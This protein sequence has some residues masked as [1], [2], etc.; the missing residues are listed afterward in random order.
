M[1]LTREVAQ[2]TGGEAIFTTLLME[3]ASAVI[4]ALYFSTAAAPPGGLPG[5]L[6]GLT[7]LTS[8]GDPLKDL[9]QLAETVG[10]SAGSGEVVFIGS[11]GTASSLNLR[12]DIRDDVVIFGSVAVPSGRLICVDPAAIIHAINPVP[13]ITAD[14]QTTLHMDSMPANISSVGTPPTVAA[15]TASM[16]QTASTS[17]RLVARSRLRPSGAR[18]ALRLSTRSPGA[19][20]CFRRSFPWSSPLADHSAVSATTPSAGGWAFVG[21]GAAGTF[22]SGLD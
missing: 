19:D 4:D 20:R 18:T 15:P 1:T 21:P 7:P 8:L 16:L 3:N 10:G 13:D 17:L 22:A 2:Y 11:P 5:L 14:S 6:H 9:T 12:N